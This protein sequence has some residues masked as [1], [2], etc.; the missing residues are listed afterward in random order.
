MGKGETCQVAGGG[1][2]GDSALESKERKAGGKGVEEGTGWPGLS[3]S[4]L[5]VGTFL[6]PLLNLPFYPSHSMASD[7]TVAIFISLIMFIIPSKIPGLTQ[8]PS[9]HM[10]WGWEGSPEAPACRY[11]AYCLLPHPAGASKA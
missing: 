2:A 8:N 11:I 5:M 1:T 9:K 6:C 3:P 7:G 10:A 4:M